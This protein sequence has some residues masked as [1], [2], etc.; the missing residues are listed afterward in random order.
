MCPRRPTPAASRA[1]VSLDPDPTHLGQIL[2]TTAF[3]DLELGFSGVA[4]GIRSVPQVNASIA[5]ELSRPNVSLA[6]LRPGPAELSEAIR[7]VAVDVLLRFAIGELDADR[8]GG[9][10]GCRSAPPS[11]PAHPRRRLRHGGGC[12]PPR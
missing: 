3:G 9:G 11:P 12:W 8:R 1:P 6:S 4:P 2:A 5:D 7:E 10:G